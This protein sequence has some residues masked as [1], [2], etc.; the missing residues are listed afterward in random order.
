M[1]GLNAHVIRVW[2]KRYGAV[3]PC[4]TETNRR[5]YSLQ[6]IE[7]LRLLGQATAAGHRISSIARLDTAALRELIAATATPVAFRAAGPAVEAAEA[8]EAV[9][10]ETPAEP[11]DPCQR[12]VKE[13]LEATQRFDSEQLEEVLRRAAVRLGHSGLLS[14]VVGPL[15]H[16]I[17]ER[18]QSGR[19]TA[20]HEHF[21]TALI[22]SFLA[23]HSRPFALGE[24]APRV[25]VATPA[26]QLH[27]LGAVMAAASAAN[28]GWRVIYLGASLPPEEI[29]GAARQNAARAVILSLVYPPDDRQLAPDL[30][31]L[32]GLLPEGTELLAGGRAAPAYAAALRRAGALCPEGLEGLARVLNELRTEEP[33]AAQP[34]AVA[35]N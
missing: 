27:E 28:L 15:A 3:T 31:R 5:L 6:E 29:A 34:A 13:A 30:E 9:A 22:R 24:Q 23:T 19:I 8:V 18:W 21:A 1:T 26:G 32:R 7:R 33:A 35:H 12:L 16:E 20:A 25:V 17:G 10:T 11:E 14:R 4:R 2:E